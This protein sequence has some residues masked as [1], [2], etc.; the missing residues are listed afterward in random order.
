MQFIQDAARDIANRLGGLNPTAKLLIGSVMV[1]LIMT[2]YL[3]SLYAGRNVMTPLRLSGVSADGRTQVISYLQSQNIRHEQRGDAILVPES[4]Q[5]R[6]MGAISDPETGIVGGEQ[7]DFEAVVRDRNP[8]ASKDEQSRKWLVA[9]MNEVSRVLAGWPGVAAAQV[10]IDD[11]GRQGL[12]RA[13]VE[14]SASVSITPSGGEVTRSLADAVAAFV[15]GAH[16][17]LKQARVEV[18]DAATGARFRPRTDELGF[19]SSRHLELKRAIEREMTNKVLHSLFYIPGVRVSVHATPDATVEEREIRTLDDPKIRTSRERTGLETSTSQTA[20]GEAGARPNTGA[21]INAGGGRSSQFSNETADLAQENEFPGAFRRIRDAGGYALQ[22]NVS[23]SVPRSFFVGVYQQRQNDDA[24]EPD[25]AAL[26]SI[27][28]EQI[29][30]IRSQI[31]PLTDTSAHEGAQTGVVE[32][33]MVPDFAVA[34]LIG[35]AAGLVQPASSGAFTVVGGVDGLVKYL[36]L[37]A[38][39]VLSLGMMLMMV[40]KANVRKEL[41]TAEEMVGLPAILETGEEEIIGEADASSLPL[42]GHEISDEAARRMELLEELNE[43]V[44]GSPDDAA[45]TVSRWIQAG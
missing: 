17:P 38:L 20:A 21:A 3:V 23:V 40:K 15:A 45:A 19:D 1:I 16:A 14:P 2:L 36:G 31:V 7:I 9:K 4:E 34:G 12:G 10:M 28:D 42:E 29:A 6:V 41:P 11:A 24:A 18:I 32:V 25:D 8:F 35:G 30:Q 43:M 27:V 13:H 26:Q 44:L 33:S 37:G 22:I 39:A 5:N